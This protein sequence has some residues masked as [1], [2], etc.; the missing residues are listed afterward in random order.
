MNHYKK[1]LN[2]IYSYYPLYLFAVL[3]FILT[4]AYYFS[5]G[6]P[7]GNDYLGWVARIQQFSEN[8]E[9]FS[10]WSDWGFGLVQPFSAH[11]PLSLI[12]SIVNNPS[13][14]L[15]ITITIV[16]FITFSSMYFLAKY[17][18]KSTL[19]AILAAIIFTCNQYAF[20]RFASG[21][22][23]FSLGYALLPLIMLFYLH[24]LNK[25]SR[26]S[27]IFLLLIFWITIAFT[28]LDIIL[29]SVPLLVILTIGKYSTFR[30]KEAVFDFT[31]YLGIV[32]IFILGGLVGLMAVQ[33]VPMIMGAKP[34]YVSLNVSIPVQ[35]LAWWS[36]SL[37]KS[38]LG[39]AR[40]LGVLNSQGNIVWN[41]HPFLKEWQYE[42]A[43]FVLP[44]LA[45]CTLFI[46]RNWL[47]VSLLFLI[48]L[49]VFLA[50][51]PNEP[52]SDI[53]LWFYRNIPGFGVLKT[54]NR[55]IMLL[56]LSYS[57]LFSFLIAFLVH[58]FRLEKI[59]KHIGNLTLFFRRNGINFMI[60]LLDRITKGLSSID[61][62]S[63]NKIT[64]F[65]KYTVFVF[66]I[67]GMSYSLYIAS[68]NIFL[69]GFQTWNPPNEEIAPH[70][71]LSEQ[72]G[73]FRVATVPYFQEFMKTNEGV[74]THDLGFS[75]FLWSGHPVVGIGNWKT[76]PAYSFVDYT[77]GLMLDGETTDFAKLLGRYNVRYIVVQGYLPS[78]S[79]S[80]PKGF[81]KEF[82]SKFI[83]QQEGL[84]LVWENQKTKIYENTYWR[85]K[86]QVNDQF[87]IVTGGRD[88][89]LKRESV[90]E[91][92]SFAS[93][94]VILLRDLEID[95]FRKINSFGE[96]LPEMLIYQT[97]LSDLKFK[98]FEDSI[99]I[100]SQDFP[101]ASNPW[102]VSPNFSV[103][104][105]S[106]F[107]NTS[108]EKSGLPT[109]S[110]LLISSRSESRTTTSFEVSTEDQY[111]IWLRMRFGKDVGR[112]NV[113]VDNEEI[114]SV[115][116]ITKSP[117]I[118]KWIKI[119]D[120]TL[121]KGL[122]EFTLYNVP[123]LSVPTKDAKLKFFV[124]NTDIDQ[125]VLIPKSKMN[126]FHTGLNKILSRID[127]SFL[128]EGKQ[129]LQKADE[130]AELMISDDW[131]D[132]EYNSLWK[133]EEQTSTSIEFSTQQLNKTPINIVKVK[134]NNKNYQ[135]EYKSLVE[136]KFKTFGVGKSLDLSD[137]DY[138]SFYYAGSGEDTIH[139]LLIYFG[140]ISANF[141]AFKLDNSDKRLR[142][143]V[144]DLDKPYL[145]NG[146]I[147]W[148][149]ISGMKIQTESIDEE[150][151]IIF[152]DFEIITLEKTSI[153]QNIDIPIYIQ[154]E[155]P[156]VVDV[157][158]INPN[159][160]GD[161]VDIQFSINENFISN[162]IWGG[163]SIGG[164]QKEIMHSWDLVGNSKIDVV[165]DTEL[166]S[167]NSIKV[168]K[169]S[170]YSTVAEMGFS[171][172]LDLTEY[173][174][175]TFPLEINS[176]ENNL[177]NITMVFFFE[178][179]QTWARFDLNSNIKNQVISFKNPHAFSGK[180]NWEFVSKIKLQVTPKIWDGIIN[181][182]TLK[183]APRLIHKGVPNITKNLG[184]H[185]P[186]DYLVNIE[187]NPPVDLDF[188]SVRHED[189]SILTNK[190]NL[191][192]SNIE[193]IS[194]SQYTV[195]VNAENPYMLS[196]M[197][198]YHPLWRA[199]VNDKVIKP[200]I[201][202]SFVNGFW[203]EDY[204]SKE[205][206]IVFIGQKFVSI[207]SKITIITLGIL[208]I[209]L[210]QRETN[211][212]NKYELKFRKILKKYIQFLRR[213]YEKT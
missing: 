120:K 73:N 138:L 51:G 212:F 26:S 9:M 99:I 66:I 85:E 98:L 103:E 92:L 37:K 88:I 125:I 170:P 102:Y 29:Y 213:I 113:S 107:S 49:S 178:N 69:H 8:N 5:P 77:H 193:R 124:S 57:L 139:S 112:L 12:N 108:F 140:G 23:P 157:I 89:L 128:I 194:P 16:L 191:V 129:N 126:Y 135:R 11:I 150:G 20:S 21:H 192:I 61:K 143:Y 3:S 153:N 203:I 176:S 164:E 75:S 180:V 149:D 189:S 80:I 28:R 41:S 197:E 63:L 82:Q 91:L 94:D 96:K 90:K 67:I 59:N 58:E 169:N 101:Q 190:N 156:I 204:L 44:F 34:G 40:E 132:K 211:L 177:E 162:E 141:V 161:I 84:N 65:S 86:M 110:S 173:S 83:T 76:G 209:L 123:E 152:S 201:L 106:W 167:V 182:G 121:T 7:L 17:L 133:A 50:K 56:Y 15:S 70:I 105:N 175:M 32:T 55:W 4:R 97:D 160:K 109:Y 10:I 186:G 30:S 95:E 35:E 1:I 114:G 24:I 205:I 60:K 179:E 183:G 22:L 116:P 87:A 165:E 184:I 18:S 54:P 148:S 198:A 33:L 2:K 68:W 142:K 151:E 118:F 6:I 48:I 171:G 159:Y 158:G 200:I 25:Q 146:D 81:D 187:S 155:S 185:P 208:L 115:F 31:K 163:W 71:W 147:N 181:M 79:Q 134:Y 127:T 46:K 199:Y 111:E 53:Y 168:S 38:F 62:I 47:T 52:L 43:M 196:F 154:E 174:G 74:P 64:V 19:A 14:V 145:K 195:T 136:L 202:E 117:E 39:F 13:L 206:E 166:G 45:I 104:E 93:K 130:V 131:S 42:L 172:F 36:L 137:K 144:F 210:I 78:H 100:K 72:E 27:P 207:G 122:H 188:V 119:G